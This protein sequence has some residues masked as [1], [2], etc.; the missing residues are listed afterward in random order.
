MT[1]CIKNCGRR[2]EKRTQA[3]AA[4]NSDEF[5]MGHCTKTKP[6]VIEEPG[7]HIWH[8]GFQRRAWRALHT[9]LFELIMPII[10]SNVVEREPMY[11]SKVLY[12]K[13]E[14]SLGNMECGTVWKRRLFRN[15]L[16]QDVFQRTQ[17]CQLHKTRR[18][19]GKRR[20]GSDAEQGTK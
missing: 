4:R 3:C 16:N 7:T 6:T 9:H 12:M 17:A 19:R 14:L 8:R 10:L 15:K 20:R 2:L 5:K 1:R 13:E 11:S 18:N